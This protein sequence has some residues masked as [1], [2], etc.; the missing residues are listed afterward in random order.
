MGIYYGDKEYA[1]RFLRWIDE[2]EKGPRRTKLIKEFSVPGDKLTKEKLEKM[3]DELELP[4]EYIFE[5]LTD[6]WTTLD[7]NLPP[8]KTWVAQDIEK[9]LK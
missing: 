7:I 8:V 1:V 3:L 5:I 6:S 9:Y 2:D 4:E